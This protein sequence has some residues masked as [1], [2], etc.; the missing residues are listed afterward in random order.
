MKLSKEQ[1]NILVGIILGDGYVQATGK[2]NARL[3]LEH[4]ADQK[5]Y[6]IWKMSQFPVL[7]QG[8]PIYME[9]LHPLSGKTY[10][11]WRMQ[12][13]STPELGKWRKV[14]YLDG[15]KKIPESLP[16]ILNHPQGLAVWYM[17]DGYYDPRDH[18]S[19]LYLGRV[20]RHEAELAT[21]T[22]KS[23]FAISPRVYDKKAK[24]FALYFPV[25]ETKKLHGLIEK[26]IVP[27]L[28]YKLGEGAR[29]SS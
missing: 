7:F 25:A 9:R 14:F 2:R 12:S 23:N 28:R 29:P 15:K 17:D 6:L 26:Y 13:N 1:K 24:G 5:D 11:Y 27:S 19:F 8:K 21:E 22:I 16:S 20:T 18:G 3:R 4:G 10:A